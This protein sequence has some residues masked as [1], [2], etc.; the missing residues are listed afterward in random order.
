[1]R[2]ADSIAFFC[3]SI[4][5]AIPALAS[6]VIRV[7]CVVVEAHVF[8]GRLKLHE[9]ARIGHADVGIH[10]GPRV[11]FIAEIEQRLAA[12]DA[13]ADGGDRAGQRRLGKRLNFTSWFMASASAT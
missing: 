10:F 11:L 9:A 8:G 6:A 5:S 7:I 1:M 13:D 12:E 2:H 4:R 3:I